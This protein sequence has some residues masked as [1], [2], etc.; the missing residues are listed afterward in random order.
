MNFISRLKR[1]IRAYR[2]KLLF[3]LFLAWM[4]AVSGHVGYFLGHSIAVDKFIAD[5]HELNSS[6]TR[7]LNKIVAAITH[8]LHFNQTNKLLI[9]RIAEIEI[10]DEVALMHKIPAKQ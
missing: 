5:Q 8:N 10:P 4:M 3:L 7:T 2:T 9:K 6:I 1:S